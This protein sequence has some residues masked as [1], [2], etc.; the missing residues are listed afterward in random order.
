MY[1]PSLNELNKN[2]IQQKAVNQ[3]DER[4]LKNKDTDKSTSNTN[5]LLGQPTVSPQDKDAPE[6]ARGGKHWST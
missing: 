4:V 6:S 5:R 2:S 3:I 1:L